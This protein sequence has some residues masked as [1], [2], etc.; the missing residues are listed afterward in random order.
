MKVVVVP[1]AHNRSNEGYLLAD[2]KL[3][4]LAG[5]NET[6]FRKLNDL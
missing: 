5:F 4:S 1:E 3:E 6:V 2:L